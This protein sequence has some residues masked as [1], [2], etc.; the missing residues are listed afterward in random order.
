M[1]MTQ[2]ISHR[3]PASSGNLKTWTWSG[4]VKRGNL[5]GSVLRLFNVNDSGSPFKQTSLRFDSDQLR[6]FN[7]ANSTADVKSSAVYRDASAWYHIILAV[8]TIQGTP[9]NRIK[10]YVNGDQVTAFSTSTYP[11]IRL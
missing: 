10:L 2:R 4:W 6:F 8:D 1:R 5:G 7:D 9:A 11:E 3:T